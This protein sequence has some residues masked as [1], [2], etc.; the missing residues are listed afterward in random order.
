M[1]VWKNEDRK[2]VKGR[3]SIQNFVSFHIV[4][5]FNRGEVLQTGFLTVLLSMLGRE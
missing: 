1:C 3:S 4:I 2:L 5:T